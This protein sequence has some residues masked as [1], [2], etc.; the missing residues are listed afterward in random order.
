MFRK[1]NVKDMRRIL[2]IEKS[3]FPK[4]PYSE[5]IFRHFY[6]TNPEGFLIC[7][8][9]G[10]VVG[11]AMF[12]DY[13]Y[14]VSLAV[15]EGFRREGIGKRLMEEVINRCKGNKIFLEVRKSNKGAQEFYHS[16][17]FKVVGVIP[18][19]YGHEDALMMSR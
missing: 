18:L 10:V 19:Y 2:E 16:L 14:V 7:E 1:F 15:D 6:F 3:A 9:D 17:G 4:S 8:K 11:Y 5:Y 12:Y 13:G